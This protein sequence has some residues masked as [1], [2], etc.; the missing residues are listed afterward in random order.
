MKRLI[1]CLDGTW[2]D[3]KDEATLTNVVK[4]RRAIPAL[5]AGGIAQVVHYVV[6]IGTG[7]GGQ[8]GF[9]IGASGIEVGERVKTG[10]K[11]LVENYAPG[12]EIYLFGFSRGAFE[13][14]SLAGFI[15]FAGIGRGDGAFSLDA[16]WSLYRQRPSDADETA[17]AQLR[18]TTHYPAPIKCVG[19]WDT[20]GNLGNPLRSSRIVRRLFDFHD[21][22]LSPTVDVGLHALSIDERRGPFS[23]TLWTRPEGASLP[24]HQ[25]VEQVWFAGVHADVG[26]GYKETAQ[27]DIALLWMAERVAATT[28]LAIN[29]EQLRRVTR[30]DPLGVQ[31]ASATGRVL[32]WSAK[33]PFVRLVAQDKRGVW[34]PRRIVLGTWRTSRVGGGQVPVNETI[35]ESA[36]ARF[37]N[38]VPEDVAGKLRQIV[39]R[40][41]NLSAALRESKGR[42]V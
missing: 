4:L 31:H 25:H 11:F 20:V 8:L 23:P 6:G 40:P 28:D 36:L 37:G 42:P 30:P 16:A 12:D 13:A 29:F 3:D 33:V 2:N 15:A 35:H 5:D 18:A 9:A 38:S 41:R 7:Y 27:S 10:Y 21:T 17:L 32:R 19:V 26:G 39:Y 14:R 24:A 1:C 22:R 34:T